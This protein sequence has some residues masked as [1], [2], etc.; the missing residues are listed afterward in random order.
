M[1]FIVWVMNA[2]ATTAAPKDTDADTVMVGVFED[3]GVAHDLEDGTLTALLDRG[4]AK[5]KFRHL[6][7]AHGGGRRWILVGLGKRAELDGERARVAAATAYGRAS[8][9]GASVVCWEV[10][11]H[12]DDAIAGALAEGTLLAAY[13]FDRYRSKTDDEPRPERLLVSAHHD[14]SGAV[15]RGSVV[16]EAANT[17][18]DLQNTPANDMTPTALA[19]AA[20]AL[21]GVEVEVEGREQIEARGMG[22]FAAVARGSDEDPKL[23]TL[24]YAPPAARGP[25]LGLVGKAV[26]FD[27]GGISLK[28]GNKMSEMKFDMSGGAAVIAAIGAI[29]RLGL[30]VRVTGVV[31]ATENMPSG[32]SMRPGDVLRA[33]NGTTIEVIN[34][35]AEGRLVLADCLAHAVALGAERLVDVATLTGAIV[36]T[37]GDTYSG[38]FSNDD[39]WAAEVAAAGERTG[40]LA[41]RLPLHAEYA[42]LIKGTYGDINNAVESR[43]AGSIVA[44]EFLKRFVGDV[45]W[46]HVDIAGAA[47]DTGRPYATKGG[48]GF[49]VRLLTDLAGSLAGA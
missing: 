29:A 3:E 24:R 13:R 32:R 30:P 17:A 48:S 43:K 9:L 46:A 11:H 40:E 25:H 33:M 5:R 42:D 28:P 37:F 36:V 22:A 35:D 8:E 23:I 6:A 7:V 14:V 20:A 2:T 15:D 4:E 45:P 27:S 39:A 41:W 34:T 31:G 26:T 16:A 49:G 19:E 12:V 1:S 38:L 47:W 21:D 18:R 44:A 10:P